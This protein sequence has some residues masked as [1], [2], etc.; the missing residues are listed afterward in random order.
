MI[1]KI[2]GITTVE[3]GLAALESGADMLGFN[4]HPP[5]P[6]YVTPDSCTRLVAALRQAGTPFVAVGVFVNAPPARVMSMLD[7]CHLDLAQLSGDETPTDVAA[8]RGLAFK[9][10]RATDG[11]AANEQAARFAVSTGAQLRP[12]LL[13]DAPGGAGSYGGTGQTADWQV[14]ATITARYDVL[15]AGGLTP[16]NVAVAIHAVR[17][18]GVDVASGVESAPG[19]KDPAR[20]RAFIEAAQAATI[21][22]S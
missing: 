14:A 2:C 17:P 9:A 6:R 5:S 10:I 20:M 4:F 16:D 22:R 3:D 12:A 1:V 19:R 7:E 8:L 18:W 13:L 21:V 15:L 11:T